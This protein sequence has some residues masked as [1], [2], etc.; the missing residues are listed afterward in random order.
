MNNITILGDVSRAAESKTS[1]AGKPFTSFLM[2]V[3]NPFSKY[4]D[5]VKVLAFGKSAEQCAELQEGTKVMVNGR[6]SAEGWINKK[7]TSKACAILMV[8]ANFVEVEGQAPVGDSR[9][10]TT[11]KPTVKSDPE[12]EGDSVPF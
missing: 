2:R 11:S 8:S 12:T 9:T 4:P 7:D 6:A 10:S 5:T 3:N 1:K